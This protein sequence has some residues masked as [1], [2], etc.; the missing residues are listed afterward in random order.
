MDD[1]PFNVRPDDPDTSH[2]AARDNPEVHWSDRHRLLI[3]LLYAGPEG[4]TDEEAAEQA[5]LLDHCFWKRMGENR[6]PRRGGIEFEIVA[7]GP[8]AQFS[9]DG[10]KRKGRSGANRK[11]SVL[12]RRGFDYIA[13]HR[14]VPPPMLPPWW[15]I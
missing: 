1:T 7:G 5:H 10:R 9:P 15:G 3:T 11:V 8:L 12:T 6:Q 13:E 2:E 4:L 14:L